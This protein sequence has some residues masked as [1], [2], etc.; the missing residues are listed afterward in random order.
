MGIGSKNSFMMNNS[1]RKIARVSAALKHQESDRVPISDFF[2]GNFVKRWRQELGLPDDANPYQYYDLDYIV[3]GPNMDPHIKPFEIIKEDKEEVTVRTGFACVIRKK[4]ADPMPAYLSWNTQTVEEIE[5]FKFDDPWDKRRYFSV[6]DDQINCIGDSY[7]RNIPSFVDRVKE[8][9]NNGIPVFGSVCEGHES[10]WRIIGMKHGLEMMALEPDVIARFVERIGD[11]MY[12]VG[13][14]QIKA[15]NGM[16]SGMYIW[17]DV[18]YTAGMLFSPKYWRRVF[19][20][21]VKRLCELFHNHHLPVIYHGC[22]NAV[23]I[24]ED[25]IEVGVNG[26]NPLEA[27]SGLDVVKLKN[28]F[29]HRLAFVGNMDVLLWARNNKEEIKDAVL[30]KLNAAKGGGYI[31]QSDHSVPSNI[32]GESYDYAVKLVRKY[33][34]YPLQLGKYD[35]GLL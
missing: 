14:A 31:F 6:G 9:V 16:L 2:W 29:G 15:A 4:F 3:L 11:F 17:G 25:F 5:S 34:V 28:Q 23:E 19:K 1:K 22:G 27:K 32:S 35:E 30:H 33:G 8:Q 21:V 13:E 7:L 12:N 10:L 24:Y 18:A 20:P 26:Y